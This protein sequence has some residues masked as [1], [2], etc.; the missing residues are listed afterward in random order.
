MSPRSPIALRT[1]RLGLALGLAAVAATANA[2]SEVGAPAE[3]PAMRIVS[4][5][6]S[7]TAILVAIGARD[8]IV[9]VDDFSAR[10]QPEVADLPR[11]GGLYN[12]SLEAVVALEPD[13]VVYVPSAEQRDFRARLEALG[14]SRLALNPVDFDDVVASIETLGQ[15]VGRA[16]AA[17]AR[18]DAIREMRLQ[19]ERATR[20]LP[21]ARVVLVLQREPLFVAG[22][23]SFV[24]D[25]LQAVGAANLAAELEA[26][27]PRASREWLLAAGPDVL[28]DASHDPAS[29]E[30]YWA[31]WSSLPA[32]TG[33]RVHRLPEGV[34]TLPGPY[35]D[36]ALLALLEAVH[37]PAFAARVKQSAAGPAS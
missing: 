33:D 31:R 11:V 6:P 17:S 7:L 30:A 3:A 18:T 23:G 5:N 20:D 2:Q 16:E 37:G 10:A 35:L 32:V 14:I 25:M 27:W 26:T 12:P 13:L 21:P 22:P 29:A 19:A 24:D 28:L 34:A 36:E 4:L 8:Q 15:R 1:I 9:G